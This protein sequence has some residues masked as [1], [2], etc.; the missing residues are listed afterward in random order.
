MIL[1]LR[2]PKKLQKKPTRNYKLSKVAEYIINIQKS[3][4]ILYT[5][6]AQTNEKMGI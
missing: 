5:N 3:V 4:A 1:N 6:K 2:D